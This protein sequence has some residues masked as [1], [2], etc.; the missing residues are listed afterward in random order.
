MVDMLMSEHDRLQPGAL[1]HKLVQESKQSRLLVRLAAARI[2]EIALFAANQ[3]RVRVAGGRQSQGAQGDQS[4]LRRE[5]DR[6][7]L[8]RRMKLKQRAQAGGWG[9]VFH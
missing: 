7:N 5:K 3:V 8:A 6:R 2:D 9:R 1:S 4:N